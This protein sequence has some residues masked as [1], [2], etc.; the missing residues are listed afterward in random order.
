MRTEIIKADKSL[1]FSMT[2]E[3]IQGVPDSDTH[4]LIDTVE[5]DV[6]VNK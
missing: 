2:T 5:F 4:P 1:T 6:G 3:L